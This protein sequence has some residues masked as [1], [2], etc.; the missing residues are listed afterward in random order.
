MR[1]NLTLEYEMAGSSLK[2]TTGTLFYLQNLQKTGTTEQ[3][4]PVCREALTDK[5]TVARVFKHS[6]FVTVVTWKL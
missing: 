3:E 6:H 2:Q 4:C 1:I 5:V